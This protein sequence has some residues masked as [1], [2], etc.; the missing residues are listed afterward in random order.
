VARWFVWLR[1][2]TSIAKLGCFS[3]LNW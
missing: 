1:H 2:P 3:L